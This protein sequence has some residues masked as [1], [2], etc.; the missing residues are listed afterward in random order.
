[1]NHQI[2]AREAQGM[3]FKA[4]AGGGVW[5]GVRWCSY[6]GVVEAWVRGGTQN[7]Q[8]YKEAR[9]AHSSEIGPRA[10]ARPMPRPHQ[11]A[12][13]TADHTHEVHDGRR[14]QTV[15]ASPFER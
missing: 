2:E 13:A 11:A 4:G 3:R 14:A 1:M 10:P 15:K 5:L 6:M 9:A 8:L 7:A 12:A